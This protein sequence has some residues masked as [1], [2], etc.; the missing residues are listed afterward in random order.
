[1]NRVFEIPVA[2]SMKTNRYG[3]SHLKGGF[4]WSKNLKCLSLELMFMKGY[5]T[6]RKTYMKKWDWE[7][8]FNS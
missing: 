2:T 6:E 3:I 7:F 4:P 1:M 8:N 5:K